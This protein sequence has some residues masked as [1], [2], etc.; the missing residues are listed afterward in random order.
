MSKFLIAFG[1]VMIIIIENMIWPGWIAFAYHWSVGFAPWFIQ[2]VVLAAAAVIVSFIAAVFLGGMLGLPV[3]GMLAVLPL[4]GF[5]LGW[6]DDQLGDI[7]RQ[8]ATNPR[9]VQEVAHVHT[10]LHVGFILTAATITVLLLLLLLHKL[11]S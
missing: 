10:Y 3:L 1:L 11:R 7:A 6:V 9:D 4:L 2:V 8:L 5:R